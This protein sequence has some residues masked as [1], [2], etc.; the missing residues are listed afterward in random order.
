MRF[1]SGKRRM[2]L[3]IRFWKYVYKNDDCW[4][5]DCW[6]WWGTLSS[7]GYG[8]VG[9]GGSANGMAL[10]HRVSWE[11]KNGEIPSGKIIMHSCDNRRCVNPAHLKLGTVKENQRD[12]AAKGRSPGRR[13]TKAQVEE[14][15]TTMNVPGSRKQLAEKFG[16]KPQTITIW[17]RKARN[18]AH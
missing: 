14:I 1:E 6:I 9:R 16:V 12:M 7:E 3:H 17:R 18:A 4:N 8:V 5:D 2:L 13:L 11:I 15:Q 10:A